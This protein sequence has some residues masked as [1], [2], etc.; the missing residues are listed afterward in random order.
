MKWRGTQ[1]KPRPRGR[2]S[3]YIS[4]NESEKGF[5]T[6]STESPE[7]TERNTRKSI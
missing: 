7:R 2:R 5:N 1:N 4:G 3:V 6:E